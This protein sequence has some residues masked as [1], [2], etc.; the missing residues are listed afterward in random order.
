MPSYLKI[1]QCTTKLQSGHECVPINSNCDNVKLKYDSVTLTC[2]VWTWF[3]NAKHRLDVVDI[4]A[5]LFQ[6]PSMYDKLK[7]RTRVKLGRTDG[8]TDRQTVR[9]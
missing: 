9:L 3:L 8:H 2:K 1:I 4:Y 7:V 6:N 5:K